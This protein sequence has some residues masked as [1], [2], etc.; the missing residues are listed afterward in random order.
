MVEWAS[1]NQYNSF[2]SAKGLTYYE[3]YKAIMRWMK[4]ETDH[5]P[6]PVEVNLDPFAECNNRCYFCVGQRYLRD[7]RE[8]VGEMRV[9]P[10]PYIHDLINFLAEWGVRGLCISGG[11]EPSLHPDIEQMIGHARLRGLDVALVTNAVKM[12]HELMTNLMFCRWVALSVNAHDRDSY[13]AIMGTDNFDAVVTNIKRLAEM[14]NRLHAPV[15]LCCKYLL[16]PET[17]N[18]IFDACKLAKHLGVQDFHVRPV[19]FEREDI[20][21]H[22]QLEFSKTIIEQQFAMCHDIEDP[23]FRVFTIG[24]KFSEDFHVVHRFHECLASPL[25]LPLLTDGNAYICVDRK[26]ESEW[27]LGSAYPDP[28]QILQ[29]WGSDAHRNLIKRVVV[30]RCSRCTWGSY[31]EQIEQTVEQDRMCLSFP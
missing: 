2:N 4:G 31:N 13:K 12:S 6:P 27:K 10:M 3:N 28:V 22:K 24:H 19:D 17:Q 14:R 29:W 5:L 30:S 25:V 26:M 23:G 16:L 18:H 7:K 20:Q 11:G 1:Q 15:D 8:E 9:L 21:G